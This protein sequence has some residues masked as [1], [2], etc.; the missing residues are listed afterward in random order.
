MAR[1]PQPGSDSG[2]WGQVLNDFIAVTHT[3]DGKLRDNIIDAN[4][5]KDNAVT[6]EHLAPTVQASL[7]NADAA[8]SG[9]APDASSSTKGIVRLTNDLGGT[10]TAPTVPGLATKE[11]TITAGTTAQYYRGDKTWQALNALAVPFTPTGSIA[12]TTVQ[13]AIAEVASEAGTVT[14]VSG[15][16]PIVSSG[17]ATPAISIT[18][19]SQSA[20]GSISSADKTK[21]DGIA[22]GA[23]NNISD[24]SLL[25]RANHT[26]TQVSSTISDFAEAA[27]DAMGAMVSNSS[28]VGL[29]YNDVANTLTASTM[30]QMSITSDS[31][32]LKLAGD[33]TTPGNDRYY[34][35]DS[36]GAKGYY[37][38]P[39]GGG[40][41]A[42]NATTS[43]PG[44]V[45]LAGDL[46][47]TSSSATAPVISNNAITAAKIADATVTKAKL[48]SA[49]QASLTKADA[50]PAVLILGPADAVPGGTAIGTIILRT[51]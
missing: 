44:L 43:T 22:A 7:A 36:S 11:P 15:A 35:T 40:G 41:S 13:A 39:V 8:V 50:T 26:G 16:A 34:G 38:L 24:A 32:G 18:P 10:A 45:Q 51:T 19:A 5:I 25:A 23:T 2:T 30:S 9:T 3:T 33:A 1:L 6:S 14:A 37:A 21:L 20:A 49:V 31:S 47:G 29:A 27:Q 12:A 46:G 48:A 4:N 28:T 42:S 17:G